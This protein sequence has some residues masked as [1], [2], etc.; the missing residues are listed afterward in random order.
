CGRRRRQLQ[1]H[2]DAHARGTEGDMERVRR[3]AH[4]LKGSGAAY[5]LGRIT[6]CGD[7]IGTCA[8]SNDSAG[9]LEQCDILDAYLE[10]LL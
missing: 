9:I 6:T 10:S 4:D 3:L 2:H 7:A 1:T 5:G 8:A